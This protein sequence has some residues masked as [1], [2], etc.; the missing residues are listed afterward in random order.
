MIGRSSIPS[1][2]IGV[3]NHGPILSPGMHFGPYEGEVTT[4]ENAMASD[5]SWEVSFNMC[6]LKLVKWQNWYTCIFFLLKIFS[7]LQIYKGKDEYEYID[8]GRESHS[9]WTRYYSVYFSS[10]SKPDTIP[11]QLFE[12]TKSQKTKMGL[13]TEKPPLRLQPVY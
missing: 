5:F 6:T 9:N 13:F 1:A 8:A 7:F 11:V 2:G 12:R 3:I 10:L 4:R